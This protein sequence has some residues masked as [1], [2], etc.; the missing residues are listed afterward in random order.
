MD[1]RVAHMLEAGRL[2]MREEIDRLMI[3]NARLREAL[4]VMKN[5]DAATLARLKTSPT[6]AVAYIE[7]MADQPCK[8]NG[9]SK[10]CRVNSPNDPTWC[11]SAC[12]AALLRY[13]TP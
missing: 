13:G 3:E 2:V 12:R 9:S 7:W 8:G 11:C 1:P 4:S 6:E 10:V 5:S